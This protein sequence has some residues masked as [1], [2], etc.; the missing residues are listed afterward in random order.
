MITI[1]FYNSGSH[2]L[3]VNEMKSA[4]IVYRG[5]GGGLALAL[6]TVRWDESAREKLPLLH[7]GGFFCWC[8]HFDS[9]I[10]FLLIY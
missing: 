9:D 1:Y 4:L 6:F 5:D 7:Y 3:T 2:E 10:F 8:N